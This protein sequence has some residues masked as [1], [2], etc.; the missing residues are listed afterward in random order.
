[1]VFLIQCARRKLF[2][3]NRTDYIIITGFAI[4]MLFSCR[5]SKKPPL[6]CYHEKKLYGNDQCA[7]YLL[8]A[9]GLSE[10]CRGS[11]PVL[12]T[13]STSN[14]FVKF[15]AWHS[16]YFHGNRL[17]GKRAIHCNTDI[18]ILTLS[19]QLNLHFP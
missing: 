10:Y 6:I 3:Y 9:S 5:K 2:C 7:M 19:F 17:H 15:N 11:K 18:V 8:H 4:S 13:V 1:M 14:L 12:I 16:E